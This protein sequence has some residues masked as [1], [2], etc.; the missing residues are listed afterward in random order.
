ML[1]AAATVCFFGFMRA[2]ELLLNRKSDF[3]PSQHLALEDVATDDRQHPDDGADH[4]KMLENRPFLKG[5]R[6]SAGNDGK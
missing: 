3:D 1:W 5:R 6:Y 2:G 4:T